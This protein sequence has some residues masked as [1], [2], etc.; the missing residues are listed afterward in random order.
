MQKQF[1]TQVPGLLGVFVRQGVLNLPEF[2]LT[3]R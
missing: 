2:S 1:W 3:L